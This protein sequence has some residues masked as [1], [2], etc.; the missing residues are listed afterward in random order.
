MPYIDRQCCNC[1]RGPTDS[2]ALVQRSSVQLGLTRPQSESRSVRNA[3]IIMNN[4]KLYIIMN[5]TTNRMVRARPRAFDR[6]HP[7]GSDSCSYEMS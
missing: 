4:L 6:S 1:R 7:R 3:N 2:A 5:I